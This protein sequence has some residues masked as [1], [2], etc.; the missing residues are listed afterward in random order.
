ML[1]D[2]PAAYMKEQESTD[3]IAKVPTVFDEAVALDGKLG[4]YA[5]IAR[6][7]DRTWYAGAMGN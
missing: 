6:R 1:A 5:A 2:N 4:E 7:K 3:F